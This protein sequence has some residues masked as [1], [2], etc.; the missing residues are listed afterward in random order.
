MPHPSGKKASIV[1][2]ARLAGVS[3]ATVSR[4]LTGMAKVNDVKRNR[5][6]EV[7]KELNFRPSATARALV[8]QKPKLI[9]VIAGNTTQYGYAE[10]IRGIEEEA[11]TSGFTVTIT[12]VE[13]TDEEHINETLMMVLNQAIAG[14][15]VLKFDPQ[16]MAALH[17][18]P[19]EIPT[20]AISGL[21]EKEFHQVVIK[22]TDAAEELVDYLFTLGHTSVHH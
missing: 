3:V 14:V 22:E 4:V 11:R 16:G 19:Q 5:I 12:V 17:A 18:I 10:T 6:L 21:R 8:G 9:S 13:T 2:V 7:I 20:V 15:I 1:D